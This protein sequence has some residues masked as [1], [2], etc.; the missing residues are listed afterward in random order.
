MNKNHS[1]VFS[2]SFF[3]L[4]FAAFGINHINAQTATDAIPPTAPTGFSATITNYSEVSLS[5]SAST[6]NVGVAGYYV[7]KNGTRI[8]NTGSLSYL[9]NVTPGY[10]S[11]TVA[12]YDAAGNVSPQSS[13]SSVTVISDTTPPAAPANFSATTTP[14]FQ[15]N[16]SWSASTDNVGVAGYYVYRNG[17]RIMTSA[18]LTGTS[19]TDASGTPGATY[20]YSVAAYDAA[21]NISP[22]SPAVTVTLIIDNTPPS[23]PTNFSVT[24]VATSSTETILSWTGSVDNVGVA[25][26]YI[27][28]N[29]TQIAN[30]TPAT[31]T[32]LDTGLSPATTY[33]YAVAAYDAA[34]NI[35]EKTPVLNATTIP[36]D[37]TPPFIPG[38][39]SAVATSSTE[40]FVSWQPSS[41]N[42][43]VAGYYLYRNST[44]IANL[45]GP[46]STTYLDSGLSPQLSY[47]YTVSA[48]AA[49]NA[50]QQSSPAS[51]ITPLVF[52]APA[53][54]STAV[55]SVSVAPPLVVS[56]TAVSAPAPTAAASTSVSAVFTN[57]LYTGLRSNDVTTLQSFLVNEGY[58]AAGHATGFYGALTEQA[59]EKFQC[60]HAIVCSGT[61]LTTGWGLVG[62]KTRNVL[63]SLYNDVAASS[64]TST[65]SGTPSV[66]QLQAE[67]QALEA[68]LSKLQ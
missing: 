29:G 22:Q 11:Y 19:Y 32:Y 30:I 17:I 52:T 51:A 37:L 18:S 6:D 49:G 55:V 61:S 34:G 59:V 39:L 4:L 42:V 48:Y 28:R 44:Q 47:I 58:L 8:V 33:G 40:I 41:D 21:G 7:Y 31:T 68:E 45:T 12:A 27:Y 54:S 9:D 26:Y 57:S 63:N 64:T 10:Y 3:V 2:L 36:L 5:W 13:P 16:L 53:A 66:A 35:S 62:A 43:G 20:A 24:A 65:A 38:G 56:S 67:I 23:L 46:T 50:S 1:F 14:N 25:G 60:D 15:V